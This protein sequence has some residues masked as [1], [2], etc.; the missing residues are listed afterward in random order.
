MFFN[1]R[2]AKRA[3]RPAS[4]RGWQDSRQ[5]LR[6]G[7]SARDELQEEASQSRALR[8]REGVREDVFVVRNDL[9]R[10]GHQA[11][12]LRRYVEL[13][14]AAVVAR[15]GASYVS[16]RDALSHLQSGS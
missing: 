4:P 2:R 1:H 6:E 16:V 12:T 5:A 3:P 9:A 7:D 11:Q 14:A 13:I 15:D 10:G 8:L